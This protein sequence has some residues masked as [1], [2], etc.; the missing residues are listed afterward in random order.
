MSAPIRV[1]TIVLPGS[2]L[3][4]DVPGLVEGQQVE[5]TVTAP[6]SADLTATN[7]MAWLDSLPTG[8]RSYPTWDEFD[9]AFQDERDSWDR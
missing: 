3:E 8:P 9:R 4:I 5:V 7:L 6:A 2:K 1:R